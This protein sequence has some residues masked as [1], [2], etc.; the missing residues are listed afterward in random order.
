MFLGFAGYLSAHAAKVWGLPTE[1]AILT[2]MGTATVDRIPRRLLAIRRQ[3]I[4]FA[5][6]T[7][8]L[9]QMIFFFCL[10][11]PSPAARTA[12]SRCRAASSSA[13]STSPTT[14]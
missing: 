14:A 4:Y 8:A 1:L 7:L 6:V 9:A 11:A 5:M 2:G 10:Q 12:S 13:W 3:G